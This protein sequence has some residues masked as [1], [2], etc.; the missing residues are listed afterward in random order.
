MA[1]APTSTATASASGRFH[2][3]MWERAGLGVSEWTRP[4]S[5]ASGRGRVARLTTTATMKFVQKAKM[6]PQKFCAMS[7]G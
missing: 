5:Y 2:H 4:T 6:A 1:M 7:L 3:A